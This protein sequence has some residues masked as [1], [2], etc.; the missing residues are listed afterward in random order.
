[1]PDHFH[2]LLKPEPAETTPLI[3]K[4]LKEEN[5]PAYHQNAS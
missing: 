2:L 1:M 5:G 3:L 4:E